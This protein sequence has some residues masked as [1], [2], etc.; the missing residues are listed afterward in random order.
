[1]TDWAS[2]LR[3]YDLQLQRQYSPIVQLNRI[4][5]YYKVHGAKAALQEL[6]EF[7]KSPYCVQNALFHAIRAELLIDLKVP[8]EAEEALKNAIVQTKNE[9]EQ[10][11]LEKKLKQLNGEV[12]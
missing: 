12:G 2:I 10:K 9:L 6:L 7:E 3:L 5:P 4:V 11:H 8:K 1:K